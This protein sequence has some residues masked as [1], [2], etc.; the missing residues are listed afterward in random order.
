MK[1]YPIWLVVLV[2]A[3]LTVGCGK[4]PGMTGSSP[5]ATPGAEK[6][7]LDP[8]QYP[9]GVD[10]EIAVELGGGVKMELVLIPVGSFVMGDADALW[11]E[12]PVH[13]VTIAKAFYLGK[14]EVTQQQWGAVMGNNPSHFKGPQ[15][16]VERVSWD[17][18]QEFLAK[19]NEK[20]ANTGKK[21][22]L[23]TEAQ[24][25]YACRAGTTTPYSFGDDEALLGEFAWFE[26]NSNEKT[27]PVGGKK[28][29]A[30]GLYDMHG[31][32]W[33]WCQDWGNEEYYR[34]SPPE[35]PTGPTAGPGRIVRGGGWI[36]E[37]RD[38]R[39]AYRHAFEPDDRYHVLGFRL[40]SVLVD[41]SSK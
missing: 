34:N 9:P 5:E 26:G 30:W 12:R 39:S 33:E 19:L 10:R 32:V 23:P 37:P 35:D 8:P 6:P 18:C 3:A 25:E 22:G 15:N 20:V 40:A 4:G 28:P 36:R 41:A 16:P 38:C 1:D 14:Y 17:D 7:R 11:R 21:F 13:Q 31:N 24:W 2:L 29:N 27:H